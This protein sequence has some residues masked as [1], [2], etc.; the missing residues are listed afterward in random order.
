MKPGSLLLRGERILEAAGYPA[1]TYFRRGS[2]DKPLVVFLPGGGHLARIAYGHPDLCRDDFLD[3][4]L[5]LEGFSLLAISYPSDHPVYDRLYPA[6]NL[7]EWGRVAAGVTRNVIDDNGLGRDVVVLGWSMAGYAA[8]PF[9]MAANYIGLNIEAFVS[10][11]ATPPLFLNSDTDP[12]IWLNQAGLR[13]MR[14][15]KPGCE[16]ESTDWWDVAIEEQARLNGRPVFDP[17]RYFEMFRC[18]HPLNLNGSRLRWRDGSVIADIAAAIDDTGSFD[19]GN[20]PL[21]ACLVPQSTSDL[22]HAASDA[23]SWGFLNSQKI[24]RTWLQ[25]L[26]ARSPEQM[27]D[28]WSELSSVLIKQV[29]ELTAT[30]PGGH[31]FFTGALGAQSTASA[32]PPLLIKIRKLRA[33]LDAIGQR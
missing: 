18:N 24:F 15:P 14:Y 4:W 8:P 17:E 32:I 2:P 11:A 9:N 30:I 6:M 23:A 5:A 27:A 3:H 22:R 19:Y 33:R 12:K 29:H 13:E 7:T 16:G 26:A 20:Y 10:L 28:A 25:P 31:L 21:T 1:L